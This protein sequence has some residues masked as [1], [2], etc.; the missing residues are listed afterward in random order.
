MSDRR[1]NVRNSGPELTSGMIVLIIF[2]AA[3]ILL[4]V[5]FICNIE[6]SPSEGTETDG[7]TSAGTSYSAADNGTTG[8][9][10]ETDPEGEEYI[11]VSVSNSEIYSGYMVLVNYQYAFNFDYA[12]A[13]VSL[14]HNEDKSD[15]YSL[16]SSSIS[17]ASSVLEYLNE[18]LDAYAEATGDDG[19]IINSAARTY[20]EQVSIMEEYTELYGEDY[21]NAY[22]AVP[23]YSEHHTGYAFDI[24]SIGENYDSLWLI[25]NCWRYGFVQ[26]YQAGKEAITQ[27][28]Y[29]YWH[30]RYVGAPH[31]EIMMTTNLCHEE[32]VDM[33]RDYTY[34]SPYEFASS[35]DGTAYVLYFVAASSENTEETTEIP[36]PSDALEY[37]IE[38]NNVD[39]FVVTVSYGSDTE[40]SD[41]AETAAAGYE[42]SET[43]E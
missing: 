24:A 22:V 15:S 28:S 17:C 41:V 23:G 33:L 2:A 8:G 18:F 42:E 26:R 35:A 9:S 5:Y 16:A 21:A 12:E 30:Y 19:A 31:A 13:N 27:I 10:A 36:I 25:E 39:G 32:Y 7:L 14:Y 1:R 3:A 4:T 38:G 37:K 43:N 20:E 11:S 29:E 34:E 6:Y 40:N